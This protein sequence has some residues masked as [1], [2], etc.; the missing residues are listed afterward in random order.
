M[1][2]SFPSSLV[3]AARRLLVSLYYRYLLPSTSAKADVNVSK[4]SKTGL[5]QESLKV[6]S[7]LKCLA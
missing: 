1:C 3:G 7:L 2:L 6:S 5:F 4:S